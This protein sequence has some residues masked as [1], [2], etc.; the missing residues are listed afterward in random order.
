MRR[1]HKCTLRNDTIEEKE[2]AN[3]QVPTPKN[4]TLVSLLVKYTGINLPFDSEITFLTVTKKYSKIPRLLV[5][6]QC[7]KRRRYHYENK[8]RELREYLPP[9]RPAEV[10]SVGAD[11]SQVTSQCA[12][13]PH[14]AP[15]I[16]TPST[17]NHAPLPAPHLHPSYSA[18]LRTAVPHP[19]YN[20]TILQR[21]RH[22]QGKRDLGLL[23][24]GHIF[25]VELEEAHYSMGQHD[26][27]ADTF[28]GMGL[29]EYAT[30]EEGAGAGGGSKWR[31]GE[32][33]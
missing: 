29:E 33:G 2:R 32:G 17:D 27:P 15:T 20:A 7:L 25:G 12:G 18:I 8:F 1:H 16:S 30:V 9:A 11:E 14:P 3:C 21:A 19:P 28:R 4:N 22:R 13:R 10:E 5:S 24:A 31:G 23:G 26:V 6:H